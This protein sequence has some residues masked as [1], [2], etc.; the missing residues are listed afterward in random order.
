MSF[1]G[2]GPVQEMLRSIKSNTRE[3]RT[4]IFEKDIET[5]GEPFNGYTFD[6]KTQNDLDRYK[7]RF[8]KEE[9]AY[10]TRL[11]SLY[12][13]LVIILVTIIAFTLFS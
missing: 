10:K 1:I 3:K 7:G 2:F 13:V 6:N 8:H 5:T 11:Y 4:T 12:S 9:K